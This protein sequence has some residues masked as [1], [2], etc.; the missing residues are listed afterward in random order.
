M[1]DTER[2]HTYLA[3][4]RATPPTHW[5]HTLQTDHGHGL[6]SESVTPHQHLTPEA[7]IT[8]R[9][10]RLRAT[11]PGRGWSRDG[12]TLHIHHTNPDRD[13]QVTYLPPDAYTRSH[14]RYWLPEENP[15]T[16]PLEA[17]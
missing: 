4:L 5:I 7:A 11:P 16:E 9:V 3:Q 1:D 13:T 12:M 17:A 15:P 2:L 10:K 6:V 8:S 14:Y